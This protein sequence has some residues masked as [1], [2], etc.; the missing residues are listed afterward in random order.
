MQHRT[1]IAGAVLSLCSSLA[2]AEGFDVVVIGSGVNG[3]R[4]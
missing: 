1:L 3:K 2:L 4:F